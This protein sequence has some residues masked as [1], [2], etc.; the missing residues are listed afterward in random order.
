MG[1]GGVTQAVKCLFSKHDALN[2]NLNNA[3]KK[4]NYVYSYRKWLLVAVKTRKIM[5][6]S[7]LKR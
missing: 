1:G 4:K 2:S 6:F 7:Q 5:S 3:K